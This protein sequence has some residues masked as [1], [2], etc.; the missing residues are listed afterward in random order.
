M[1][2]YTY[3]LRYDYGS[4]PNPYWGICTLVI[5]KPVIRRT[6]D[7]GDWVVGFCSASFENNKYPCHIVYAMKV[8][9]KMTMKEYDEYCE[10]Q[11]P[12]KIPEWDIDDYCRRVGDCIYDYSSGGE[13]VQRIGVHTEENIERDLAGK[14]ALVSRH[15][16][17]FGDTPIELH[18]DLMP[19]VHQSQGHKSNK[20][21]EYADKFVDWI[22]KGGY[23]IN[24]LYGEPQLKNEIMNDPEARV[25]CAD[26]DLEIANDDEEVSAE[27]V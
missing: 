27:K 23:V 15:F 13:P 10:K 8:T 16:Y 21:A 1:K 19:I 11:H 25:K 22:K 2:L 4:A 20:N 14:Y 5:C 9:R 7:I 17:Y 12:E 24:T 26:R 6:A 3:L 18:D